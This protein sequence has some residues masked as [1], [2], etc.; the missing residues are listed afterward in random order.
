VNRRDSFAALLALAGG[1]SVAAAAPTLPTAA[2][3]MRTAAESG[4]SAAGLARADAV[5][6]S[7]GSDSVLVVHRG[8][9]VHAYGDVSR[10]YNL[11]SARKSVLSMLYGI[12]VGRSEIDLETTLA[13]LRIDDKQ[14]LTEIEKSA[15]VRQLLQSRSGIYHPAAYE[16]PAMAALRPARGSHAP[17]SFWYYNNWDFNAL[18]TVFRQRTGLTVFEALNTELARPLQFQDFKVS[19][20]TRFHFEAASEHPAY[21]MFLSARDLARLGLVMA[22]GGR[23]ADTP[24]MPAAWVQEC[25]TP[26]SV[27]GAGWQAYAELWWV[28]QR[29]WPFWQRSNGDVFFASGNYGQF[30]WVDRA[31]DLVIVHQTDGPALLRT[32]IDD[33]RVSPLLEA[34]LAACPQAAAA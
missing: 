8:A 22:R 9:V 1:G 20:H 21:L 27:V 11:Y 25:T 32:H 4:W 33:R 16:T 15:T 12:H 14:G 30:M 5:A 13:S 2:W 17:G 26:R 23:W 28:P 24:L 19:E 34:L 6:H 29:A 7:L 10:P 18:A 3:E 31:R